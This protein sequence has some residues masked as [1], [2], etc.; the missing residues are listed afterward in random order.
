MPIPRKSLAAALKPIL[1][2]DWAIVPS[3]RSIDSIPSTTV[4]LKQLSIIRTPAAPSKSHTIE[5][6]VTIAAPEQK[7]QAAEDRLDDQITDLLH[8]LDD[9]SIAWTTCQKVI[10]SARREL[11]YDIT[12]TITSSKEQT[13]G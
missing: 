6:V 11:G 13:N 9:L 12:L 3:G 10:V 2:A 5:F 8:A 4:Q 1:P 7:T